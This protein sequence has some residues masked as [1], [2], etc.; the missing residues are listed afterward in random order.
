MRTL[1][2]ILA[3]LEDWAQFKAAAARLADKQRGDL[4]EL[5]TKHYLL[6]ARWQRR[7]NC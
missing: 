2:G 7:T 6:L 4:F 5:L 3:G 1:E